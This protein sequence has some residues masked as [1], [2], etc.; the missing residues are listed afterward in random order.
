MEKDSVSKQELLAK[1]VWN[2]R[3]VMAWD[4]CGKD[5]AY[6]ILVRAQDEFN[7]RVPYGSGY[8]KVDSVLAIYGTSV[9]QER[10]NYGLL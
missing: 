8:A 7:G 9:L 5:K 2:C 10:K 3:D 1:A 6:R 4:G